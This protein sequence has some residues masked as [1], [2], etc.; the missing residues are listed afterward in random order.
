[1]ALVKWNDEQGK[2]A[3]IGMC[4]TDSLGLGDRATPAQP[5]GIVDWKEERMGGWVND[6]TDGRT[7][8]M[9]ATSR[10]DPRDLQ[11]QKG[12]RVIGLAPLPFER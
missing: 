3:T 12:G 11:P 2:A 4:A 1:M 7:N 6:W 9:W 5:G 10:W 8:E